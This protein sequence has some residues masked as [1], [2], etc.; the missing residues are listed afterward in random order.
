MCTEG[1]GVRGR[2]ME[3]PPA[4]S[5]GPYHSP[6]GDMKGGQMLESSLFCLRAIEHVVNTKKADLF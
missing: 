5:S 2:G 4:S 1:A 3:A 6:L